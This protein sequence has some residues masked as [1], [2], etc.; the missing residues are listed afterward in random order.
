[1]KLQLAAF[2]W[3]RFAKLKMFWRQMDYTRREPV[4]LCFVKSWVCRIQLPSGTFSLQNLFTLVQNKIYCPQL[5][6]ESSAPKQRRICNIKNISSI[7]LKCLE[8]KRD[9]FLPQKAFEGILR[10]KTRCQGT[11]LSWDSLHLQ[12]CKMDIISYIKITQNSVM[13]EAQY[14][15]SLHME[16]LLLPV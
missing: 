10:T 11:A 13:C 3:G 14:D 7:A 5:H 4:L 2:F 9:D 16:H 8:R 15:C 12:W 1:M 6:H